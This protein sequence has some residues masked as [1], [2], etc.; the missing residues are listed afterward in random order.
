MLKSCKGVRSFSVLVAVL[1]VT[2]LQNLPAAETP[3]A[4]KVVEEASLVVWN[5]TI[6]VF[7]SSFEQRSPAQRAAAA[8]ER[9]EG[10]PQVGPWT[11]ETR[12]AMVGSVSGILIAVNQEPVFGVLPGDLDPE[13][14]ETL[15][16]AAGRAAAQLRA[17]WEAREQQRDLAFMVR[18]VAFGAAATLL[19]VGA[20]WLIIKLQKKLA[21]RLQS[22]VDKSLRLKIGGV[23]LRAHV[24]SFER[25][26]I[27][28]LVLIALVLLTYL[29]LMYQLMRFPY[30]QP[31][32]ERLSGFLVELF[33]QL[34]QGILGALRIL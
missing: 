32:G 1:T 29:W 28:F 18:A 3:S 30:T 19:F 13:A 23:D 21:L 25:V 22:I 33:K 4:G 11:I 17:V 2:A 20:V 6:F 9:I 14:G 15:E 26:I 12:P 8:K 31:W 10:L 16:Q 24:V 34:V 27:R 5:R 7:R